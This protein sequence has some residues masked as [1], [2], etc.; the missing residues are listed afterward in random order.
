[1]SKK[2]EDMTFKQSLR[3][4]PPRA[5]KPPTSISQRKKV[6]V[7]STG[8]PYVAPSSSARK[9]S[10]Y[11]SV[12]SKSTMSDGN[13]Y[14]VREFKA[15]TGGTPGTAPSRGI[16]E[17]SQ[18]PEGINVSAVS[19]GDASVR[20]LGS[21]SS[22]KN[23]ALGA[24]LLR[25]PNWQQVLRQAMAEEGA[26]E[27]EHA[28]NMSDASAL[29]RINGVKDKAEGRAMNLIDML[30]MVHE[31]KLK[32]YPSVTVEHEEL[33]P[34]APFPPAPPARH[35][36]GVDNVVQQ[37][38]VTYSG[39]TGQLEPAAIQEEHT[40]PTRDQDEEEPSTSSHKKS[41]HG[42]TREEISALSSPTLSLGHG[43]GSP[44]GATPKSPV[45]EVPLHK[46]HTHSSSVKAA[47]VPISTLAAL[48]PY[49]A[50]RTEGGGIGGASMASGTS[51]YHSV[52]SRESET[53]RKLRL[54]Y[55][56]VEQMQTQIHR[57]EKAVII[58]L[59][60]GHLVQPVTVD[61]LLGMVR[62]FFKATLPQIL[63]ALALS[64][65]SLTKRAALSSFRVTVRA[66]SFVAGYVLLFH[67]VKLLVMALHSTLPGTVSTP[68]IDV[69]EL[70]L[71][72]SWSESNA[73]T[74]P[75]RVLGLYQGLLHPHLGYLGFC[76]AQGHLIFL[77]E[78]IG[79][80]EA[81]LHGYNECLLRA[82]SQAAM[83]A[84]RGWI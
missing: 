81:Y 44:D 9:E 68:L 12:G 76:W 11:G 24:E 78:R 65:L 37:R 77:L 70:V 80:L 61:G 43:L 54:L 25:D 10:P 21:A 58:S 57:L 52:Q 55:T 79:I 3:S 32:T 63:L 19:N 15:A 50:S 83:E 6:P 39:V 4:T 42:Y 2:H 33:R 8:G 27:V 38:R 36:V 22:D 51:N 67:C 16:A 71:G 17:Y 26:A 62:H 74:L 23:S 59:D 41:A 28:V 75:G 72:A 1:M 82:P 7:F 48:P 64:V 46:A 34:P 31:S 53:E 14:S 29:E 5:Q 47:N 84:S 49:T 13:R 18:T 30:G 60:H 69:T 45:R 20:S 66:I 40:S 35:M 73:Y 56:K